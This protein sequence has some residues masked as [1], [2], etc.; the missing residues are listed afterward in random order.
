MSIDES[1]ASGWVGMILILAEWNTVIN[2]A[3]IHN[4]CISCTYTLICM[5]SELG[6]GQKRVGQN[7]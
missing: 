7:V 2:F 3:I 4:C 1:V 6:D 5:P